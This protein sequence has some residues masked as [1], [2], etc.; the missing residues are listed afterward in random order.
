[1]KE[2]HPA[3]PEPTWP[4]TPQLR[5]WRDS[6]DDLAAVEPPSPYRIR[7][8]RPGDE[9]A[10]VEIMARGI[11][12]SWTLERWE[13]DV[14]QAPCFEP[15]SMFLATVGG[16]VVGAA[17]A[18]S[19]DR[20]T[21]AIGYVHMV[22][23]APEHRGHKLG[24]WLTLRVLHRFQERGMRAAIL[25]TDDFRLSAIVLYL[26]LGFVPRPRHP[27]HV[28]RWRAVLEAIRRGGANSVDRI[29]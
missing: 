10:W 12:P 5:M 11:G 23:V 16:R 18:W 22:A 1:M 21:S 17:T 29:S 4:G 6:L 2:E 8:F 20:W 28:R 27:T 19:L 3:V 13:R 24:Y 25:D 9:A 26:R 14:R 7:S 15:E